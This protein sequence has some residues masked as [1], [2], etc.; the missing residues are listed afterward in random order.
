[1]NATNFS[2]INCYAI[3]FPEIVKRHYPNFVATLTQSDWADRFPGRDLD[4]WIAELVGQ[5]EN[6][7]YTD[8][9]RAVKGALSAKLR[10]FS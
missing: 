10:G 4:D 8:L 9:D 7:H 3:R 2:P 1:M 6:M 5:E